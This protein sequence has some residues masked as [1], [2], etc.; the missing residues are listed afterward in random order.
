MEYLTTPAL[1]RLG[2]NVS[3]T[4]T[5]NPQL[6]NVLNKLEALPG[7]PGV[8]VGDIANL[9]K[10]LHEL[11]DPLR[12]IHMLITTSLAGRNIPEDSPINTIEKNWKVLQDMTIFVVNELGS[13][14]RYPMPKASPLWIWSKVCL[15]KALFHTEKLQ[16]L[17]NSFLRIPRVSN[18]QSVNSLGAL[19]YY[20]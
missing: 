16:V 19:K 9:V 17:A 2:D 11:N 10:A 4:A 13:R 12:Q 8:E 5:Y 3:G 18:E 1:I 6:A 20:E 14:R 7:C 15:I